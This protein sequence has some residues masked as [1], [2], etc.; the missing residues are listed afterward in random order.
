MTLADYEAFVRNE[1]GNHRVNV[2]QALNL[3]NDRFISEST[4]SFSPLDKANYLWD[5]SA[6]RIALNRS[7]ES[8]YY[9][10]Y[11][12]IS[13]FNLIIENA[14]TTTEAS[15][16]ATCALVTGQSVAGHELF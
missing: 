5:E 15:E 1:Y 12:S 3:L 11:A 10:S 16:G 13:T 7:D 14:L 2:D 4:L 6:D 9:N 8:T